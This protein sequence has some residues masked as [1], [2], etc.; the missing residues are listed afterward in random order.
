ME[1]RLR[2]F[3]IGDERRGK[4]IG[5]RVF[6]DVF[7]PGIIDAARGVLAVDADEYPREFRLIRRQKLSNRADEG[8]VGLLIV[9]CSGAGS[10][11]QRR[12]V[13][14]DL[15]LAEFLVAHLPIFDL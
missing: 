9:L 10:I 7:R 1:R 15:P 2:I 8:R 14:V 11:R 4:A 12:S 13:M 6:E 5:D 3:V